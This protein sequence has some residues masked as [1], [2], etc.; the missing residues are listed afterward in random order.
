MEE[1]KRNFLEG[2]R[3]KLDRDLSETKKD[4]YKDLSK[5][6]ERYRHLPK[7]KFNSREHSSIAAYDP[8]FTI[9]HESIDSLPYQGQYVSI[10]K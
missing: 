3:S 5:T 7:I 1:Q 9:N 8:N 4:I 6:V 10:K 2:K